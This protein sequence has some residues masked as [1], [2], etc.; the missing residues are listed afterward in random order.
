MTIK[1]YHFEIE[2]NNNF[3]DDFTTEKIIFNYTSEKIIFNLA[4]ICQG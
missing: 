4:A 1:R 3:F 2:Q